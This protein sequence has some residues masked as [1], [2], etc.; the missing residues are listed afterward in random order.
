MKAPPKRKKATTSATELR[1]IELMLRNGCMA[2]VEA[3]DRL[4]PERA[5]AL[6]LRVTMTPEDARALEDGWKR[7]R[8]EIARRVGA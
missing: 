3:L 5:N 2:V 6:S 1:A 8:R 4:P 7:L